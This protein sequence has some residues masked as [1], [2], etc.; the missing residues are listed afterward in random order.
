M[1]ASHYVC[2]VNTCTYCLLFI[3]MCQV[4]TDKATNFTCGRIDSVAWILERTD[5]YRFYV[6]YGNGTEMR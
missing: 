5:P 6:H 1:A 3:Q 2:M 4:T